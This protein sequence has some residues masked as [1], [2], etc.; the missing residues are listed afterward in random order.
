MCIFNK[1]T[2]SDHANN[3]TTTIIPSRLDDDSPETGDPFCQKH[4]IQRSPSPCKALFIFHSF[5]IQ[6]LQQEEYKT[7]NVT[8]T[9]AMLT[10]MG[11][12]LH[13]VV[14]WVFCKDAYFWTWHG[15]LFLNNL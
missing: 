8:L 6:L 1:L 12:L 15:V 3:A 9:R 11:L 13:W 4:K 14:L 7:A 2:F 5:C 10:T